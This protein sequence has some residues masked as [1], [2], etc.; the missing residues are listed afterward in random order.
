MNNSKGPNGQEYHRNRKHLQRVDKAAVTSSEEAEHLQK[1]IELSA[2]TSMTT[3]E[4]WQGLLMVG[5]N[6][7]SELRKTLL[8]AHV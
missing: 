8:H 2:D 5:A 6:Q 1:S 3:Q 7:I 4:L